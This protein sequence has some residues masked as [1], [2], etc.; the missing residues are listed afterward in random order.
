MQSL[1]SQLEPHILYPKHQPKVG[2]FKEP[3]RAN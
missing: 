3:T 2:W 1:N